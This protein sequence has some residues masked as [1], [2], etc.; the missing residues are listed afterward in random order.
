MKAFL[1]AGKIDQISNLVEISGDS[2]LHLA[3]KN[4]HFDCVKFIVSKIKPIMV[5][6]TNESGQTSLDLA[7]ETENDECFAEILA[8]YPTFVKEQKNKDKIDNFENHLHDY[9]H[10]AINSTNRK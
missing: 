5:A 1:K 2:P 3:T 7:F 8:H 10:V 6:G 4:G 9:M